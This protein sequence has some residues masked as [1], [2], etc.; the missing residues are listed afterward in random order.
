MKS[1]YHAFNKSKKADSF[2]QYQ[3]CQ[4]CVMD[5]SDSEIEFDE[6][7]ICNH[8]RTYENLAQQYFLPGIERQAALNRLVEE[9]R[10]RG[11]GK[12]Y[13]C[14]IGVSGGVDSTFLAYEVMKLEL[15]PL[16]VHMDNGWDSELAVSN[17]E[18][19][20]KKLNI[21][22]YTYVMNWEEF[23]NLQFAFLKASVSDAEI[24]TDHA[25]QGVLY[26]IAAEEGISY[27]LTGGNFV[28]EGILPVSWTY[29]VWDW[30]YIR[31]VHKRFG[32]HKLREYPHYSL[33]D[34]VYYVMVRKIR[35]IHL[36]DYLP[37]VKK[38]VIKVLEKD[39]GW[40]YYGGKH[41]ESIYTR[42][43]QGFILPRKFNIDKRRAHLSTLIMSGGMTREEALEELNE[44]PY[45]ESLQEEDKEYVL[46]KLGLTGKD[47]TEIMSLP[48]K[49]HKDY[50]T[51][52]FFIRNFKIFVRLA[53][54]M[55]LMP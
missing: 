43:F 1:R 33:M 28:T 17:I 53:R 32:V 12:Q 50:P 23:K 34:W 6:K 51:S 5:T 21:D 38:E 25:I 41:Y 24:P 44:P 2:R 42:F 14:V 8:C 4:R 52:E 10:T 30:R 31:N 54:K 35:N 16:A 7:G 18:K 45:S 26:K 3:L 27:I 19:F 37:Y 48:V 39:L 9:I 49:N 55:K 36:L 13:D 29:G 47:F 22:L 11:K 20:L 40:K 15:R 46:K